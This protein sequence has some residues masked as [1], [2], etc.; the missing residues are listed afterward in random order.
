MQ[1]AA[2][3]ATKQQQAEAQINEATAQIETANQPAGETG[4]MG[5]NIPRGRHCC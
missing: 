4:A 3:A 5:N 2:T 1:E